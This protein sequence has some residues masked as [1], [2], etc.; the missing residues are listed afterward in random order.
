M[1]N[2]DVPF[3]RTRLLVRA[4]DL[5]DEARGEVPAERAQER[6]ASA[7]AQLERKGSWRDNYEKKSEDGITPVAIQEMIDVTKEVYGLA[8]TIVRCVN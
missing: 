2:T 4:G 1:F 7:A 3:F 5:Y 8:S 6:R